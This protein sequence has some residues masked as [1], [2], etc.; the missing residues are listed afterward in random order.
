MFARAVAPGVEMRLL[1]LSDALPMFAVVDRDRERL[2]QWLAWVDGARSPEDLLAFIRRAREKFESGDELHASIRV[3]GEVVGAIGHH[4][5]DWPNRSVSLGYWLAPDRQGRGVVTN[6]ARAMLDYLF[7]EREL[8]RVEIRCGTANTR[9]GA[10]ARR[11]GFV[12]EGVMRHAQQVGGRWID[13]AVWGM[14]ETEW[15]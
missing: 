8:H 11:L 1:E 7:H 13:L 10:V 15:R 9:S 5:I 3:E 14:L 12:H 4:A 2:R 6:C